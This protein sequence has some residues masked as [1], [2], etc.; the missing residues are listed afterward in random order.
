LVLE[1]IGQEYLIFGP[2]YFR[3]TFAFKENG[4]PESTTIAFIAHMIYL[5][6]IDRA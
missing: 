2:R 4:L 1:E 3:M 6:L 5:F